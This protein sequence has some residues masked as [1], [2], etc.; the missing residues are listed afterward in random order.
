MRIFSVLFLL[1]TLLIINCF[2]TTATDNIAI[3]VED[4]IAAGS[5]TYEDKSGDSIAAIPVEDAIA[6][7]SVIF[8]RSSPIPWDFNGDGK[9][10][11]AG[12]NQGA[13][14][15]HVALSTGKSFDSSSGYWITQF[16]GPGLMLTGDF[17]GDGKTDIAG[18]NQGARA[19]HVALSTG[20]SFDSSG[21]YWITQFGGPGLMLNDNNKALAESKLD[22]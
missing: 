18:W 21:G 9:T 3:P 17:N 10:D 4:A 5:L 22:C 6:A 20:H 19:W 11:I 7:G 12:W 8:S 1:V 14:A 13:R 2:V 15:W 16:G